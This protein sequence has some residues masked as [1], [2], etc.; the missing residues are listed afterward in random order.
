MSGAAPASAEDLR[1]AIAEAL[2]WLE[3]EG[4][5]GSAYVNRIWGAKKALLSVQE[6][7]NADPS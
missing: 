4:H 7:A 3:G 6:T 2:R 1:A 5:T